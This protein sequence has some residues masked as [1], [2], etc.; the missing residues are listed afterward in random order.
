MNAPI[1]KILSF[2]ESPLKITSMNTFSVVV[3]E[4]KGI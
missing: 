3:G 4:K 2:S 1:S